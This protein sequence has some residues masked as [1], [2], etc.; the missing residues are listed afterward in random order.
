LIE[1]YNKS[2]GVENFLLEESWIL[3]RDVRDDGWRIGC[4]LVLLPGHSL[5]TPPRDGEQYATTRGWIGLRNASRVSWS[6]DQRIQPAFDVSGELDW[7][8]IEEFTRDGSL[9]RLAGFEFGTLTSYS[10]SIPEI[11]YADFPADRVS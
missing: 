10:Q 4:D 11:A 3:I 1:S 6:R 8:N 7:G 9:Y 2:P 5:W